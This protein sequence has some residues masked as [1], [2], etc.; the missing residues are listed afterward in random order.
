MLIRN[1]QLYAAGYTPDATLR[2]QMLDEAVCRL[3][4]TNNA[5]RAWSSLIK[6]TDAVGIKTNR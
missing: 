5:D 3:T 2:T 1:R 4:G 6:P